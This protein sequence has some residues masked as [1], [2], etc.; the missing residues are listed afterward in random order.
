MPWSLRVNSLVRVRPLRGLV[1][2]VAERVV[3][4]G[5]WFEVARTRFM[6]DVMR[7][8]LAAGAGQL[9][10]LGAGF[11]SRAYRFRE[12]L[13]GVGVFEVDHPATS[14]LKRER[15]RK[16]FGELPSHVRYV[17]V[18]FET[19]D[20]GE[21]LA[22]AGYDD[23]G[24]TLFLWSGVAPY[25]SDDAVGAVLSFVGARSGA[26]S[27]IVF[28]YVFRE[29]LD[30]DD[31]FY[32]AAQLRKSVERQGEPFRSGV[33]K[34]AIGSFVEEHGL[35]LSQSLLADDVTD[36]GGPMIDCGGICVARKP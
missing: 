1:R 9:V 23:T 13:E 3:P 6:D 11:D 7:D 2:R 24:R 33:P 31:G 36:L 5:L 21:R 15:L 20:L 22:E 34:G 8:E 25:I 35:A 18:D 19:D 29:F 30:G 32:G 10:I 26:G 27:A 4:G 28:D 14:R 12:L 17:E 16:I